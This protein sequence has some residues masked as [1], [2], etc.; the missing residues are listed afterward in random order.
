MICWLCREVIESDE[1]AR[2][3]V[4]INAFSE[5]R[6][7]R[8]FHKDCFNQNRGHFLRSDHGGYHVSESSTESD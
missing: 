3:I 4:G 6:E 1:I 2:V 5:I 8:T 7:I